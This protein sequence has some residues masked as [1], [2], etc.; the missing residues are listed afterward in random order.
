M[1]PKLSA[2]NLLNKMCIFMEGSNTHFLHNSFCNIAV[3]MFANIGANF[4]P[5]MM[6]KFA[7]NIHDQNS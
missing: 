7:G 3:Y 6:P 5:I 1:M 4:V 2:M